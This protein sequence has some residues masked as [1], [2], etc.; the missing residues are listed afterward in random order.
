MHTST[1][2]SR[3]SLYHDHQLKRCLAP[4]T[5]FTATSKT[6]D[7]WP[8]EWQP[9]EGNGGVLTRYIAYEVL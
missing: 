9:L 8:D 3:N 7:Y 6:T 4:T 5:A 2:S 1:S